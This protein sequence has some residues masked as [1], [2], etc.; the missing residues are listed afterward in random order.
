MTYVKIALD[1]EVPEQINLRGKYILQ[2][3]ELDKQ[4]YW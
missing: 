4:D 3:K 2:N 1:L